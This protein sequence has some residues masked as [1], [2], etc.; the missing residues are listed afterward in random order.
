[1]STSTIRRK[2]T[3]SLLIFYLIYELNYDSFNTNH[4]L[5][6][7]KNDLLKSLQLFLL[8]LIPPIRTRRDET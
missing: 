4:Y 6:S 5:K 1:M 2:L 3:K 7:N 8:I